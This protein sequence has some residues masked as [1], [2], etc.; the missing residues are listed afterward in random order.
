VDLREALAW[1]DRRIDHETAASSGIAAGRVEGLSLEP[2][3][4]LMALLGDP[5]LLVLDEPTV[6]LDGRGLAQLLAWLTELREQGVTIVLV[7]HDLD[8]AA[9][10]DRTITLDAGA[11]IADGPPAAV[12]G[13]DA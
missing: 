4:Q 6:G 1:L 8:L 12:V 10:A 3:R 13:G 5:Q 2:M 9:R 7:T 11:I